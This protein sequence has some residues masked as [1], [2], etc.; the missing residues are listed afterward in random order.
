MH[1]VS[2]GTSDVSM[3]VV[4]SALGINAMALYHYFRDKQALRDA[5]VE[6]TFAPLYSMHHRL[7]KQ[8]TVELRPRLLANA[9]CIAPPKRCR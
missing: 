3:R 6:Q 4:T 2:V 8:P 1:L 5:M 7:G 9:I